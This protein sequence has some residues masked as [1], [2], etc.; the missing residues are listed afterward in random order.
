MRY[1]NKW[2]IGLILFLSTIT[3]MAKDHLTVLSYDLCGQCESNETRI[4]GNP[5]CALKTRFESGVICSNIAATIRSVW[6]QGPTTENLD[7]VALQKI[8]SNSSLIESRAFFLKSQYNHI[9]TS[10]DSVKITTY[11]PTTYEKPKV[12]EDKNKGEAVSHALIFKDKKLLFINISKISS[13]PRAVSLLRLQE[14][15]AHKMEKYFD[16]LKDYRIIMAGDAEDV[17]KMDFYN[18]KGN[19][20]MPNWHVNFDFYKPGKSVDTC[21]SKSVP[22]KEKSLTHSLFTTVILDTK[23]GYKTEIPNGYMYNY[24]SSDHLPL[25]GVLSPLE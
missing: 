3:A 24:P 8:G 17:K 16:D 21:C 9:K 7:F 19:K 13:T 14:K 23:E 22:F 5:K 18:P 1:G 12:V 20:N 15:I 11:F 6:G 25:L 2:K 10:M 4:G